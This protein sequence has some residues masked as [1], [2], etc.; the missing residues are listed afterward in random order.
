MPT[1]HG[2]VF[3]GSGYGGTPMYLVSEG[4]TSEITGVAILLPALVLVHLIGGLCMVCVQSAC[5]RVG[6]FGVWPPEQPLAM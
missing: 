2:V 1:L 5:W 4:R 3:L 6:M